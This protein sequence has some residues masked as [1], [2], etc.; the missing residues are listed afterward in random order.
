MKSMQQEQEHVRRRRQAEVNQVYE[1]AATTSSGYLVHIDGPIILPPS[2]EADLNLVG[3]HEIRKIPQ[4][5]IPVSVDKAT[6]KASYKN[7]ISKTDLEDLS[8]KKVSSSCIPLYYQPQPRGLS[9][10][11]ISIC[12]QTLFPFIMAGMGMVAAGV[13]LDNVQVM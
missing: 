4:T 9:E 1:N 3:S 6:I 10:S 13:L 2:P 11:A 7:N 8:S 5:L 12:I